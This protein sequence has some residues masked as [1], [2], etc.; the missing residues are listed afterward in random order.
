MR[1]K[2]N[3]VGEYKSLIFGLAPTQCEVFKLLKQ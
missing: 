2:S 1:Q 3:S